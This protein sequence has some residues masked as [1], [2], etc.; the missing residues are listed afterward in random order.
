MNTPGT[1]DLKGKAVEFYLYFRE[2]VG[3]DT[4]MCIDCLRQMQKDG[5]DLTELMEAPLTI[6]EMHI[7]DKILQED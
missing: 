5:F 4:G 3:R 7:I 2:L 6:F 1:M